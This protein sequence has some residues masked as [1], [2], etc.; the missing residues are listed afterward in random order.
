MIRCVNILLLLLITTIAV[1][2]NQ[3]VDFAEIDRRVKFIEPAPAFMLSQ[4]LVA[5][6]STDREKAR[7]IFSWVAQHIS[8]RT[9][10]STRRVRAASHPI[11]T[12][13]Y[14]DTAGWKGANDV[15]AEAV[16]QNMS[17]VC[18]GYTRL[19][20]KLCDFAGVP[21]V[22]VTGYARV[23]AGRGGVK[24]R[25]NHN[26]NAV[27]IDSAWQL[28]DVTWSAG[29]LS[30]FGDDFIPNFTDDYFF[31]SPSLFILDHF[32]DDLKW[33]LLPNA[34]HFREFEYSPFRQKAFIKYG[35]ASY[36]PQTGLL[37]AQVGD[38]IR[39]E[40]ETYN[41][42]AD[43]KIGADST[44]YTHD[45]KASYNTVAFLHPSAK[46]NKI[47]YTYVVEPGEVEWLELVYNKDI[48]MQYRL[49]IRK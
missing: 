25:S 6:Y 30:Y 42:E 24:F 46:G 18:D 26:W 39:I 23:E 12:T 15:V 33:T 43:K 3:T 28:I 44:C 1:A 35:I 29:Y 34:P 45:M 48:I 19:F 49:K 13:E 27:Y 9:K 4:T 11:L 41:A 38:T 17:A 2:Q 31:T 36:Q 14:S 10:R 21:A 32:P 47:K 8:Y 5:P 20:K 22:I 37:H 7:A 16:L 40:L